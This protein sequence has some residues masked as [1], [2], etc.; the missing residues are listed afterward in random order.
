MLVYWT[1]LRFIVSDY[2][3]SQIFLE[4]FPLFYF[5]V[6]THTV[7]IMIE[8]HVS[9]V[10]ELKY[11]KELEDAKYKAEAATRAKSDFLASMSHEIR[12]PMN[13]VLG[14]NTLILRDSKKAR[15]A[16]NKNSQVYKILENIILYAG[17]IDSAGNNL[18]SIINTI[19]DFSKIEA[20]RLEI[21]NANYKLSSVL[22]DVSNIIAFRAK[23][24][25]LDFQIYVDETLPDTYFGDEIRL[26]Q[27]MQNLLSNAVKYTDK[28]SVKFSIEKAEE[29]NIIQG[30]NILLKFSVQDSGIGIKNEDLD[31]VFHRFSR[32]DTTHNRT[33]EGTGLGL[34]IVKELCN[35]MKANIDLKSEYGKGSTFTVIIPQV[36]ISCE[37]IGNF[38]EK[39]EQSVLYADYN[40]PFYAPEAHILVVDD[41]KLNLTVI[42]GLLK[43]TE[44]KI[45]TAGSGNEAVNLCENNSY[46][47]ILMDQRMPQ[48]N[49]TET[50]QNIRKLPEKLNFYTPVI[51]LTAD[52]IQGAKNKYISEGFTDYLT[53]PIESSTLEKML[54][55]YLPA[56]KV[57]TASPKTLVSEEIS[58]NENIYKILNDAEINANI[59]LKYCNNDENFYMSL[60]QE[61]VQTSREKFVNIQK[62]FEAQDWENYSILVHSLKSTS[63][64]LGAVKLSE[65]SAR[66]EAASKEGNSQAVNNEHYAMMNQYKKITEAIISVCG[67]NENEDDDE[68]LEFLP[69]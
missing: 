53:K 22:N 28:G 42:K 11:K 27:I 15:E 18:V 31:K 67:Q 9:T 60:L 69:E 13:A 39:F 2:G 63:R 19:L 7:Y 36:V 8:Y 52:A 64:M 49:G 17:N 25:G 23:T 58:K 68:I 66:Q 43:N 24:K 29:K 50:L 10:K 44:I 54:K 34:S 16:L 55:K 51:C 3:Y 37:K 4:R 48:M 26:R 61:Y 56:E 46:D 38:R 59:G 33:I 41:I 62:F 21:V 5:I 47:L 6:S 12:T 30:E 35:M 65:I 14:M 45:D 1:P 40:E 32:V 57:K 20:G